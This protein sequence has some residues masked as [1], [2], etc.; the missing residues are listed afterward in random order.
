MR[1]TT[2]T[3][4]VGLA[5]FLALLGAGFAADVP[6]REHAYVLFVVLAITT[7]VMMRRIDF[8]GD[9]M[10]PLRAD[11]PGIEPAAGW[12]RGARPQ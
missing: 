5:A 9:K 4:L 8:S 7:I 1:Y 10:I 3:M 12:W 6:F 2:E 11:T